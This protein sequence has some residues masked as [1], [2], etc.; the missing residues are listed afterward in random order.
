MTLLNIANDIG[1]VEFHSKVGYVLLIELISSLFWAHP[2]YISYYY[3]F[4]RSVHNGFTQFF[5]FQ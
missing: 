3:D 4:S 2:Q 1:I 5:W